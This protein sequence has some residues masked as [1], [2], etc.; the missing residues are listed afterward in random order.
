MPDKRT[1]APRVTVVMPTYNDGSALAPAIRSI[2]DQTFH[3]WELAV[4]DDCSDDGSVDAALEQ[5]R[6]D[7]IIPIRLGENVGSGAARNIAISRSKAEYIAVMDADDISL[8]HRLATQI[9]FMDAH[10]EMCAV[11]SQLAEFGDWGGPRPGRWPT[12]STAIAAR[13]EAMKI[14]IAHPTALFRRSALIAVGGYDEACRR[15]QDYA[16]F[17]RLRGQSIGCVSEV[18]VHYRTERPLPLRYAINNGRYVDLAQRR[19][20]LQESGIPVSDLPDSPRRNPLV[21]LTSMAGWVVRRW[22]ERR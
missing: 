4:I 22:Q 12:T 2:L 7:R 8:P 19:L 20:K 3:D 10:P 13:Q 18:L 6:D 17:L 11:G 21:D 5:I 14:P 16:L 15:A 1:T 9:D